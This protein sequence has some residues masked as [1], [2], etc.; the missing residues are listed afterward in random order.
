MRN[1]DAYAH[2]PYSGDPQLAPGAKPRNPKAITLGNIGKLVREVTRL[3]GRKPIWITEYAYETS[4]PDHVFGVAW[5]TQAFYMREAYGIARRNPRIEMLLWFLARDEVRSNG[6]QSG[7]VSAG[8]RRKPSFYEFQELATAARKRQ[9]T[10]L[11][12]V[13]SA[14]VPDVRELLRGAVDGGFDPSWL[15]VGPTP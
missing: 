13:R 3:Y 12:S 4:P 7:L 2:H 9:L 11:R 8:G 10:V 14:R 6:W 1:F 15:P 5:G